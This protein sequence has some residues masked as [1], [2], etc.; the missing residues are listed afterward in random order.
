M[1]NFRW[2]IGAVVPVVGMALAA[3]PA[4]AVVIDDFDNGV[5]GT[6]AS[7]TLAD[8]TPVTT[9]AGATGGAFGGNRTLFANVTTF[10][11]SALTSTL[12]DIG[13]DIQ[14]AIDEGTGVDGAGG[15]F[16]D[17]FTNNDFSGVISIEA[18]LT[19]LNFGGAA[20]ILV[21]LELTDG[22]AVTGGVT[23]SLPFGTPGNTLLSFSLAAL[24]GA[25]DLTDVQILRF[26][27]L[28][29]GQS[30][31]DLSITS[32]TTTDRE[33]PEPASLAV[34]GI[35]GLTGMVVGRRRRMRNKQ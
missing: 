17:S 9:A 26:G 13:G 21:R 3:S 2:L 1:R 23:L 34:W 5:A 22:S 12:V 35:M 20:N 6:V 15:V 18:Q 31:D 30:Q 32:I 25:V 33:I 7:D 27:T 28:A 16:I 19:S 10:S 11:G 24:D 4:S 29:N 8:A 14:L